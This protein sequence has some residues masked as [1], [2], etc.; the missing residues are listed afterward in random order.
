VGGEE[1]ADKFGGWTLDNTKANKSV[2]KILAEKE[3]SEK[4]INVGCIAHGLALAMKDF[5][6]Y[7]AGSGRSAKDN[8]WEV[9]WLFELNRGANAIANFVNDSSTAKDLLVEEQIQVYHAKRAM[10]ISVPARFAIYLFV[11]EGV[12][13]SQKALQL[14]VKRDTWP[15]G[16]ASGG[17]KVKYLVD[18]S[19]FWA[20]LNDA[21]RFL[22]PFSDFIHQIEADRPALGRCYHGLM[23]LDAHVRCC[24]LS[25]E[26][27]E[28]VKDVA[29]RTW[30]RR[31]TNEHGSTV[32]RLLDPSHTL[33]YMLDP[34]YARDLNDSFKP[35][36]V[37]DERYEEVMKLVKRV[38][39]NEARSEFVRLIAGGWTGAV[40]KDILVSALVRAGT[41]WRAQMWS[42]VTSERDPL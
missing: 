34:I 3:E 10:P 40:A 22:Q 32:V 1:L 30:E 2:L 13:N 20:Q 8:T 7:K 15:A 36:E 24:V 12:Q 35:P 18:Y 37:P 39:G 21:V 26:Q 17:S 41:L 28:S 33:A 19:E 29:I 38:G 9:K 25:W 6:N 5:C 23:L 11:M 14:A 31:L 4:W 16:R 27:D 42:L